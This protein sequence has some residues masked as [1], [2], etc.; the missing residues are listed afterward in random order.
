MVGACLSSGTLTRGGSILTTRPRLVCERGGNATSIL[1]ACQGN[2]Y[3]HNCT[4]N[5]ARHY[6]AAASCGRNLRRGERCWSDSWLCS[7]DEILRDHADNSANCP[8][9]GTAHNRDHQ[10]SE[11]AQATMSVLV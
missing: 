11:A 4:N 8:S 7:S 1:A 3:R 9:N 5:G 10:L 6:Q 2:A